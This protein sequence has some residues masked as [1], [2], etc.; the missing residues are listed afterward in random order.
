MLSECNEVRLTPPLRYYGGKWKIAPWIIS[1]FP[2]HNTYVEPF[3]GG[4]G[5]LLRKIRQL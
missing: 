3:G 1:Y 5:V 4:A 2:A